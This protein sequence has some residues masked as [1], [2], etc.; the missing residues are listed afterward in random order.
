MC[1]WRDTWCKLQTDSP[2]PNS[3]SPVR[4]PCTTMAPHRAEIL[5]RLGAPQ[6]KEPIVKGAC[7][8]QAPV[9]PG[10]ARPA[11]TLALMP[12]STIRNATVA[13]VALQNFQGFR[14]PALGRF[15]GH[16]ALLTSY[17]VFCLYIQPR[18]QLNASSL[19][20][21][22]F[23][24]RRGPQDGKASIPAPRNRCTLNLL[25]IQNFADNEGEIS[26]K[27][28]RSALSPLPSPLH[29]S[30]QKE[31]WISMVPTQSPVPSSSA[32]LHTNR[33]GCLRALE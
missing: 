10:L 19:G 26:V 20:Q 25:H 6:M 8:H 2:R 9:A 32:Y 22:G 4:G 7:G 23:R 28:K 5:A 12:V 18:S 13:L 21:L 31:R 14:N 15:F 16:C 33:G 29:A 30:C 1:V 24:T 27:S 3:C 17:V 11:G